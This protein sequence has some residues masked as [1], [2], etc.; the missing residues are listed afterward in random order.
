[1]EDGVIDDEEKKVLDSI[2]SRVDKKHLTETVR[3]EIQNFCQQNHIWSR[4]LSSANT[5][6]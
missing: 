2:F 4:L 3:Q 5:L 1:M 6:A